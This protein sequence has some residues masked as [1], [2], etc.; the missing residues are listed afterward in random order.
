M[1][2]IIWLGSVGLTVL[3]LPFVALAG[4]APTASAAKAVVA[5]GFGF[6]DED[7]SFIT[8]KTYDAH[9]GEVLSADTYELDIKD[10]EDECIQIIAHIELVPGGTG[11]GD[12]ALVGLALLCVLLSFYEDASHGDPAG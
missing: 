7:S 5:A 9:S 2:S 11:G 10:E 1:R 8:V 4:E 6:Q 3:L 12:T